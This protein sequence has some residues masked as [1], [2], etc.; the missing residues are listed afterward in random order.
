MRS[1]ADP[2]HPDFGRPLPCECVQHEGERERRERLL[3]YSRLGALDR[4]TFETLLRTGRDGKQE[5]REQYRLAAEAAEG[6]AEHPE[7]WLVLTGIPGCGKT[8][9]AAAIVNRAIERG[10]PALFFSVA[11]LL[12]RLRASYG[13]DAEISYE[14]LSAQIRTAPLVVLDDIDSFVQTPWAHEKLF[15]LISHRFNAVLPTVFTCSALPGELD[16]RLAARLADPMLSQVLELEGRTVPRYFEIGGMVRERLA[17]LTFDAFRE[18]GH[19]LRGEPRRNLEGAFQL[20]R[21]WSEEPHGWLVFL[22]ANGCGKTHLAAAIANRRLAEGESVCFATV[23]DLLDELRSTFA[24]DSQLRFDDVLR[25]LREVDLLVLDD[26]GAHQ[27]SAWAQEKLYQL[28][29]FR[30]VGRM[31]TVVT[32]NSELSDIERRIRSRLADLQT[33]TVYE[34]TAPDYRVGA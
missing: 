34:I 31:P 1:T 5:V 16:E 18:G 32:T 12:D 9:M 10:T 15:Q 20:A 14:R 29:N 19:G 22:G 3:R 7:G 24:P 2:K 33:S 11:D 4:L 25:R 21:E 8:H 17:E 28:L 30:H 6:F 26:L 23:P 27:S 13:D